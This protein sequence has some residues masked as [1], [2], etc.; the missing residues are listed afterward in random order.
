MLLR[1]ATRLTMMCSLGAVW[2]I[3]LSMWLTNIVLWLK[4]LMVGLAIL[5]RMYSGTLVRVTVLRIGC[6]WL[7]LCMLSLEP[8]AVLVGHSPIVVTTFVVRVVIMLVGLAVL[9]RHSATSG[10]SAVLVGR[11]VVTWL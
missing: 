3:G 5:L 11:V 1:A 7:K 4:T 8:A 10:C 2:W 6:M 9:A